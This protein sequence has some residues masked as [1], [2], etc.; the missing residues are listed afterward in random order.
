MEGNPRSD[1]PDE[2]PKGGSGLEGTAEQVTTLAD[3][4]NAALA[5]DPKK[6]FATDIGY[7]RGTFFGICGGTIG[8]RFAVE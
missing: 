2:E 1:M 7:F 8:G 3:H 6:K 4:L 5:G